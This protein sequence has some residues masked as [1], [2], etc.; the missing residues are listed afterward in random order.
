MRIQVLSAGEIEEGTRQDQQKW[1]RRIYQVF[2]PVGQVAGNIPVYGKKE[3][4]EAINQAGIYE[5]HTRVRAG[6][7]GRL[8]VAI[9]GLS[10][11]S[12][13]GKAATV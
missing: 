1:Y 2:D 6:N 11:P 10:A 7:N 9:V 8:E 13:A 4:L 5:A 3:E 12:P